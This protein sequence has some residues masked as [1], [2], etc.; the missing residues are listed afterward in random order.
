[1]SDNGYSFLS[2]AERTARKP[3]TCIWCGEDIEVG[4]RY[5][6]ERS[7]YEGEMQL[8][9]W[10]PE[11]LPACRSALREAGDEGFE[12]YQNERPQPAEARHA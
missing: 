4:T 12:A 3:H 10:H 2:L 11:C 5:L 8:H 9:R 1:M 6:D 7:V